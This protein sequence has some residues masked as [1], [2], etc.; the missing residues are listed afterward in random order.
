MK[1]C[2]RWSVQS[3]KVSLMIDIKVDANLDNLTNLRKSLQNKIMRPAV[4][5]AS[6]PIL[7][8]AKA[9]SSQVKRSGALQK[10]WGIKTKTGRTAVYC[11]VGPKS[12]YRIVLGVATKGK[13]KGRQITARPGSYLHF[14]EK[15]GSR[16]RAKPVLRPAVQSQE[17]QISTTIET[18][19][20]A[21][22]E[23]FCPSTAK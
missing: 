1:S 18:E 17:S 21:G 16:I 7:K 3:G 22:I 12:A 6:R 13:S 15:D 14:L 2:A 9:N 5:K 10:S 8:A 19:V 20:A 23:K 4:T 11:V